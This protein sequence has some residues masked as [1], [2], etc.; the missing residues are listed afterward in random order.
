MP[1]NQFYCANQGKPAWYIDSQQVDQISHNTF[2]TAADPVTG[3]HSA[4][5]TEILFPDRLVKL[6]NYALLTCSM[7]NYTLTRHHNVTLMTPSI[8]QLDAI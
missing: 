2:I 8:Y 7:D 6:G 5:L 1:L 4:D 3:L